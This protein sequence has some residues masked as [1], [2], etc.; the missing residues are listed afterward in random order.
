ME[1]DDLKEVEK[2]NFRPFTRF[3]MSIGAVPSSYLAGLDIEEQ[4]LWLCSYLEKE[5][6]P[7]VNNN[8]EA[9]EELQGLFT[10]LQT[11]VNNYFANLNVQEE[12]NNKLDE[13]AS[14]GT[15]SA[16]IGPYINVYIDPYIEEQTERIN[17]QNDRINQ[18]N[19]LIS[20]QNTRIGYVETELA[21]V[22]SGAP[23]GVYATVSALTTAD[24]DHS[25]IYVV[26][27][28]GKWYYYNGSQWTAGGTYQSVGIGDFSI[29]YQKLTPFNNGL[30]GVTWSNGFIASANN[31]DHDEGYISNTSS[32][33]LKRSNAIALTK[34]MTLIYKTCNLGNINALSRVNS[35]NNQ[36]VST[37]E[38]GSDNAGN[39][40]RVYKCN[41]DS[42]FVCICNNTTYNTTPEVYIYDSNFDMNEIVTRH[43][44]D[45]ISSLNKGFLSDA[46]SSYGANILVVASSSSTATRRFT[47]FI[48]V[49]KGQILFT[50]AADNGTTVDIIG[51]YNEDF[52]FNKAVLKGYNNSKYN[53]NHYYKVESNGYIVIG[54]DISLVSEANL[55]IKLYNSFDEIYNINGYQKITPTWLDYYMSASG[56]SI[57]HT[58]N[59]YQTTSKIP[60]KKG[61]VISGMTASTTDGAPK[62]AISNGI[63]YSNL[64]IINNLN[65]ASDYYDPSYRFCYVATADC[66]VEILN[67]QDTMDPDDTEIYINP[68]CSA[69]SNIYGKKYTAIGDS[70]IANQTQQCG[71]AWPSLFS[72]KYGAYYYMRG[73]GGTGLIEDNQYGDSVLNRLNTIPSDTD[74]I[75]IVGGKNDYNDQ[76]P[77][78]TFKNGIAEI[79]ETIQ[80]DYPEARLCFAT[81]WNTYGESDP[82][83][84]KLKQYADAIEEICKKYCVPCFNSFYDSNMYMYDSTFR[85]NYA[86]ASDDGSHLNISGHE[87]MFERIETFL[88]SI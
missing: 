64:I 21:S 34:G 15:L 61:D 22:A 59:S 77:L 32:T 78:T 87:R 52:T 24:P 20:Q 13:M 71:Y 68:M 18:Q 74:F 17:Q 65:N 11:Y 1:N 73:I 60:L 56:G 79:I 51:L 35:A 49:N 27:A 72:N 29:S 67:K 53:N 50:N 14:N 81:P 80:S 5:V 63:V 30:Q 76:T 33:G 4:L 70:Y 16:L 66:F 62:I 54:N 42:E 6:I 58:T 86:Q 31:Q 69:V 8:A 55:V 9:V 10:E 75:L 84:I 57:T 88:K 82:N 23:S 37:I 19:N 44:P 28:D 39:R 47:D 48:K 43:H 26:T 40:L 3:C 36:F 85:T 12:I 25:K 41:A 83:T 45:I 2:L 38:S 46:T 7:A